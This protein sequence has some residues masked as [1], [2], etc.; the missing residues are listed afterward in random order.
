MRGAEVA[1]LQILGAAVAVAVIFGL[2]GL[3]VSHFVGSGGA[4]NGLG[5]GMV[6]GGA[7]VGFAAGGS[8]SPS[9]NTYRGRVGAFGTY[10]GQSA[11]LPQ[12]PLE[13]ALGGCLAFSAGIGVLIVSYQ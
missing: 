8:G 1:V 5:W 4:L 11:P 7:I 9:E 12:S 2:I 6:I 3:V 13:L 10:W